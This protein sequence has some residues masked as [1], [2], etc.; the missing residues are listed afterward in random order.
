MIKKKNI[1]QFVLLFIAST[2]A[3]N[4]LANTV[5]SLTPEQ[6]KL[7]NQ[8]I[9]YYDLETKTCSADIDAPV[10]T[11]APINDN[12]TVY[13]SG[14]SGP[15]ILE[16]WAIHTLKAIAQKKGGNE[17]DYVTKEHVIALLAFALGEG[18]DINNQD[19]FNPLTTGLNAPELIDGAHAVNGVQ[20][21]KSFD[22]GV[23]A[24]TRTMLGSNQNRLATILSKNT[25]TAKDFMTALTYYQRYK[26]NFFWAEAS[27]PPNQDSYFRGRLSLVTQVRSN[28]ADIASLVIG[29]PEKEQVAGTRDKSKLQFDG[30]SNVADVSDVPGDVTSCS[31]TQTG[32]VATTAL[33]GDN[34]RI[35]AFNFFV[36]KGV[37][38]IKA[39][40]IVGNFMLESGENLDTDASN[41]THKGIGQW[42][43]PNRWK[44][45]LNFANQAQ[46]RE[47][48]PRDLIVQLEFAWQESPMKE[49]LRKTP[50]TPEEAAVL[51]ERLFERS[52]GSG[53]DQRQRYALQIFNEANGESLQ[54]PTTQNCPTTEEGGQVVNA[55]GYAFPIAAKKKSDYNNF[56]QLSQVPCNSSGGCHHEFV[57]TSGFAFDLGV[58]GYGPDRSENAPVYAISDGIL[59]FVNTSNTRGNGEVCNSVTLT[60]SKD[61][62]V[63][64]YGHLKREANIA[65]TG[66]KVTAGQIVGH[67]GNTR[68]ADD[69]APHLHISRVPAG[70][71]ADTISQRDRGLIDIINS[72]FEELP[73]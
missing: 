45:L 57:P 20:S 42:D 21:F 28:Y 36:D 40:G 33:A 4:T 35:K 50:T 43:V 41:G 61:G 48:G 11:G 18:G 46:Y 6:K 55:D 23:E 66:D 24:A 54:T 16:Q 51:F 3:F 19:I 67:V 52:G 8:N 32:D 49:Y 15:F 47:R 34:N 70:A 58:N 63:Y 14:L 53:N 59:T 13:S 71:G 64:W 31:C 26:R 56:G 12:P 69:T 44:N 38:P 2:I 72:T 73:D 25:S 9:L 1:R 39:A 68:C 62:F 29:T 65:K 37:T 27:K 5:Q 30:T 22:A 10:D 17:A 60:S 7:F